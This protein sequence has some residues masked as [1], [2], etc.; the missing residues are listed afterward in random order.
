MAFRTLL[1]HAS[2]AFS[3]KL[4]GAIVGLIVSFYITRLLGAKDAGIYFLALSFMTFPVALCS[5]GLNNTVL[6][7]ISAYMEDQKFAQINAIFNKST[8]WVI[9]ASLTFTVIIC[10]FSSFIARNIFNKPDLDAVLVAISFSL[11]FTCTFNLHG[12]AIQALRKIKLAMIVMGLAHNIFLLVLLLLF[13]GVDL[14]GVAFSYSLAAFLT[15]LLG[16]IVWRRY[17]SPTKASY[18]KNQV[19]LKSSI[20]MLVIH[21]VAQ[22]NAQSSI[23]LLGTWHSSAS[24]AYFA[25]SVK[26]A[27]LI[28]FILMA[29]NRVVAPDF[30]VLYAT[31]KYDQLAEKV[32]HSSVL[33]IIFSLPLLVFCLF[34]PEWILSFFGEDFVDAKN[35][36]RIL[37]LS[38]FLYV[39]SGN[40]NL[41]LQMTGHEKV[42]R[43]NIIISGLFGIVIG[44]IIIPAHSILGSAMSSAI[45]LTMCNLLSCYQVKKNLNINMFKLW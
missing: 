22:V 39:A 37:A 23:L 10:Y 4:L 17:K 29:V 34:F 18:V 20:P 33:M 6:K 41:L 27:S 32:R 25:V 30:S 42:L 36:L 28:G 2:L 1:P 13:S 12:H 21:L 5:L 26:V 43:D 35:S 11:I 19:I 38:Q 16:Y 3:I 15:M 24:V 45:A 31:K 40:V 9:L 7:L 8:S 44:A 14:D